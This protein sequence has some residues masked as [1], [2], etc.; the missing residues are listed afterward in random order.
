VEEKANEN[1]DVGGDGS[2]SGGPDK[3]LGVEKRVEVEALVDVETGDEAA[4]N[5]KEKD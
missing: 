3:G 2:R 4:A 1:P 5:E